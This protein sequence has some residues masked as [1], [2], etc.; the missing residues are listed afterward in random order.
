MTEFL[1]NPAYKSINTTRYEPSNKDVHTATIRVKYSPDK[2]Q[3][4]IRLMVGLYK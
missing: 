2:P 1:K 4:N 3:K